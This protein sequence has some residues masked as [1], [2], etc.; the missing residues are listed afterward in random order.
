MYRQ[1]PLVFTPSYRRSVELLSHFSSIKLV[2]FLPARAS[3][4]QQRIFLHE[5]IRFASQDQQNIYGIPLL[6]RIACVNEH[7]SIS[8]LCH[9]LRAMM[10]KHDILRTALRFDSDDMIM[11]HCVNISDIV[12]DRT[13]SEYLLARHQ[14]DHQNEIENTTNDIISHAN[15]FDLSKGRVIQCHVLRYSR[16]LDHSF[17]EHGDELAND[18]LILFCLHHSAFD[19]AS[20]GIFCQELTQAYD[21]DSILSTNTDRLQY[22]DYAVHEHQLDMTSSQAFWRRQLQEYNL[23]RVLSLPSDRHRS[24]AEQRS[25]RAS[26]AEFTLDNDLS[27]AFFTYASAHQLTPFQ[28]GL[29]AFYVFL[30]KLSH[31]QSDL[32]ISCIN[33]NRYRSELENMIGMFVATLPYRMQLQPHWSF[34]ELVKHVRDNSLSILEHTHYPL[35]HIL[36]DFHEN[37]TNVSFLETVFD[38]ITASP[39]TSQLSLDEA[40]LRPVSLSSLSE[41]AKFDV[42]CAFIYD[43]SLDAGQLSCR[44]V[45]SQDLYDERTVATMSQRFQH[46]L[47]QLFSS[48]LSTIV[49]DQYNVSITRLSL[50]LPDESEE[51]EGRVFHRQAD[52]D[53]EGMSNVEEGCLIKM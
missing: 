42:M 13:A 18:D 28:L 21:S 44:F 3:F 16:P 10:Q 47:R 49:S 11:Q 43:S 19:G 40:T 25:A 7:L 20:K 5:R 30:F 35:Q 51:M 8:R 36:S 48:R 27:S 17:V 23:Q 52:V 45:C 33:A 1:L 41:V 37:Q 9:V 29:A 24:S 46:L 39:N 4:A 2:L 15:R 32:C 14:Y 38:F 31:G 6:F 50:I 34:D 53:N 26:A 12:D 22:I